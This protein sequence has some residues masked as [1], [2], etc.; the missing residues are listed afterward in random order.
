MLP[1][2]K[3]IEITIDPFEVS[4]FRK[5]RAIFLMKEKL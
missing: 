2:F 1:T 5:L 3:L 4:C